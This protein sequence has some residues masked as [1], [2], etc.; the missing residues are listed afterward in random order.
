[1]S[2]F[3][4]VVWSGPAA[5]DPGGP[6]SFEEFESRLRH[7]LRRLDAIGVNYRPLEGP[8]PGQSRVWGLR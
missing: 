7:H 1:M 3:S 8:T 6:R 2:A 5:R 4:E